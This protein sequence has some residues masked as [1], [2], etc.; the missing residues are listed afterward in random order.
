MLCYNVRKRRWQP[1]AKKM[2]H[3]AE[4]C[5]HDVGCS[6]TALIEAERVCRER[7]ARLTDIPRR[8]LELIWQAQGPVGAYA[9]LENL[10]SEGRPPAPPTVY[11]ALDFLLEQ[12]LVHRIE[13]LNAFIGCVHPHRPHVSQFL[14]C[15][16]CRS[17]IELS[18]RTIEE[19]ILAEAERS[20]FLVH[21]QII[22]AEG[23]CKECRAEGRGA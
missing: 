8:V 6:R 19:A 10:G 14:I 9:L 1:G 4:C 17:V 15:R 11:R 7:G 3:K 18:D 13:C 16:S 2:G 22:E 20:G 23:V 12:G 21:H 5:D